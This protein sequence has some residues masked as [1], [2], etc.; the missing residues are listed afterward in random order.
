MKRIVYLSTVLTCLLAMLV[1]CAAPSTTTT[2]TS[3]QVETTTETA[4]VQEK[5]KRSN[6]YVFGEDIV[7]EVNA[8]EDMTAKFIFNFSEAWDPAKTKAEYPGYTIDGASIF[9]GSLRV[10]LSDPDGEVYLQSCINT[11]LITENLSEEG[12]ALEKYKAG[13]LDNSGLNV[14]DGTQMNVILLSVQNISEPLK[15]I[16][17]DYSGVE[18]Q[19]NSY[20]IA[21]QEE[22]YVGSSSDISTD[23]AETEEEVTDEV[24][25]K[26]SPELDK[27][28]SLS[29]DIVK[30]SEIDIN[31]VDNAVATIKDI[32][33]STAELVRVINKINAICEGHDEYAPLVNSLNTVRDNVPKRIQGSDIN[34]VKESLTAYSEYLRISGTAY[35]EVADFME[36]K[37]KSVEKSSASETSTSDTSMTNNDSVPTDYDP[38]KQADYEKAYEYYNKGYYAPVGS[39][40]KFGYYEQDNNASNGK[41]EIE[42][43]VLAVDGNKMLVISKFGLDSQPFN[44]TNTATTWETCSLRTWLNDT[45]YNEAFDPAL[46]NMILS[47]TVTADKNPSHMASPGNNTTDKIFL[48]SIAEVN[49]YFSSDSAR[50]CQGTTYC[51]SQGAYKA[52][53]G[54]CWWWLRSPGHNTRSITSVDAFGSVNDFG[55]EVKLDDAAIRPALWIDLGT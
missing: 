31:S 24:W 7:I 5:G 29:G 37:A 26:V 21:I 42:W 30:I 27:I 22:D 46:Q 41:E 14:F 33:N 36:N 39:T 15:Y 45:F 53:N 34:A 19:R 32:D 52:S 17:I 1:G 9:Y 11:Y 4:A 18:N 25:E 20:W 43:T 28:L 44:S 48:L 54:N 40:I 38:E 50:Q 35:R 49:K 10:E 47:S 12:A 3:G 13:E 23:T 6:P 16:K 55:Y 8:T 2:N 51:N